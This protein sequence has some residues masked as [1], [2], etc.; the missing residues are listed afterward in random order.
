LPDDP[1]SGDRFLP[2]T[3]SPTYAGAPRQTGFDVYNNLCISIDGPDLNDA[4]RFNSRLTALLDDL[5]KAGAVANVAPVSSYVV[6]GSS[7]VVFAVKDSARYEREAMLQALEKVPPLAH[8]FAERMKVQITGTA[9]ASSYP[10][11]T[12]NVA[13][14]PPNALDDLPYDYY[15]S[16]LEGVT[17]QVRVTVRY[18]YKP[19]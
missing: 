8:A 7:L 1:R 4:A 9:G 17:V 19:R 12:R 10:T 6:S 15:S 2:S 18:T 5:V 3:G 16:T 14:F 13:G 11:P